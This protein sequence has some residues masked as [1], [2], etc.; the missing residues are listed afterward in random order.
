MATRPLPKLFENPIP[1]HKSKHLPEMGLFPKIPMCR[2]RTQSANAGIG[3]QLASRLLSAPWALFVQNCSSPP[4]AQTCTIPPN[5]AQSPHPDSPLAHSPPQPRI[6]GQ[7]P[8]A[9]PHPAKRYPIPC[10]VSIH[11][12]CRESSSSFCRS[13]AT[14]TSTV[15]LDVTP[16]YPQTSLSSVSRDTVVPRC[17]TR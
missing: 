6:T 3:P 8:P 13:H 5:P 12:G 9:H 1:S 4:N 14:C 2:G 10:T 7:A 16:P 17:S 15:R 11:C